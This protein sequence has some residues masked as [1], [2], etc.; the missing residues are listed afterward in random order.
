MKLASVNVTGGLVHDRAM[1]AQ[2]YSVGMPPTSH[3]KVSSQETGGAL[4]WADLDRA[5]EG[6]NKTARAFATNLQFSTHEETGRIVV[7][8]IDSESGEVVREIPPER[9]LAIAASI[10][11]TLGLMLDLKV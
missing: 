4:N 11:E 10:Q 6:L 7:K 1:D 5:V 3:I 2:Q 8:V 9:V